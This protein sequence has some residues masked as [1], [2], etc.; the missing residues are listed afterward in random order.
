MANVFIA[1]LLASAI[2]IGA[3][4]IMENRKRQA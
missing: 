4:T 3:V 1:T 2:F